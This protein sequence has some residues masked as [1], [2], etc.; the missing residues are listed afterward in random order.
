MARKNPAV[1][2]IPA[3]SKE[4]TKKGTD[5]VVYVAGLSA[6]GY[7]GK[8]NR[9]VFYYRYPN[10]AELD[11]CVKA[12]F[13][14]CV[15]EDAE[16]AKRT[17]EKKSFLHTLKVGD[18]L[19]SSW[20]YDQTNIDFYQIVAV[21]SGKSVKVQ[22]LKAIVT[23]SAPLAMSGS[24]MPIIDSFEEGAPVLTKMVKPGWNGGPWVGKSMSPWDGQPKSCSWCA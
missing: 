3:N 4:K 22:K 5:A 15:K 6:I 11:R 8:L 14:Q 16:K 19:Y 13:D 7:R 2:F 10:A 21:P 24:S 17:A 9:S 18:V 20:G 1:R 12:F 23:E